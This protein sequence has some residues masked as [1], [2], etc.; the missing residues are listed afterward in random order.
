MNSV[1]GADTFVLCYLRDCAVRYLD[2]RQPLYEGLTFV[3]HRVETALDFL[4]IP[5]IGPDIRSLQISLQLEIHRYLTDTTEAPPKLPWHGRASA[6]RQLRELLPELVQLRSL[7][8]WLDAAAQSSRCMLLYDGKAF[9]FDARL[10]PFM[11]VSIP[12]EEWG[13]KYHP[14]GIDS[15]KGVFCRGIAEYWQD[16][17]IAPEIS[18][19]PNYISE[20]LYQRPVDYGGRIHICF[21]RRSVWRALIEDAPRELFRWFARR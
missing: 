16:L 8:V 5:A 4:S 18:W 10:M 20:R 3:I 19:Y 6:W 14:L 13:G 17:H 21:R 15:R 1:R 11:R 7:H 12:M 9:E 2:C